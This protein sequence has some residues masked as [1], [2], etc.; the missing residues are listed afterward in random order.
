MKEFWGNLKFSWQYAKDQKWKLY[1]Y[2]LM[3]IFQ[4]GISVVVPILSAKAIVSLTNN[5]L[6]QLLLIAIM[7]FLVENMRNI[8]SYLSRYYAQVI[9]RETFTKLQYTLGKEILKLT[10]EAVDKQGT[11]VFIQRLTN[12]TSRLSDI[13]HFLNSYLTEIITDIGIFIAIFIINKIIFIFLFIAIIILYLFESKRSTKIIEEDKLFRKKQE[14]TS[15]FVGEIVRGMRD[16]KMLNSEKSF[17]DELH[18]KVIEL[19]D[20]RYKIQKID[21]NYILF[22]GTFRDT[23]NLLLIILIVYLITKDNLTPAAALVVY[24]YAG[25]IP[26]ITNCIGMLLDKVKDFNLSANRIYAIIKH[27]DDFIK[28]EFGTTHLENVK[29]NFEFKNVSFGYDKQKILKNLS[30]KINSH[31]TVAFVGKSGAGKTTIFNLLCKMYNIEKGTISIDDRDIKELDR[32]SIRGNITIIS[33]NP[34]IFNLSIKD[35]LR[36]VKENLTNKEMKEACKIACLEDFIESL[37]DKYNTIIGEGGVNLSGGQ[38]Q[39]LAI[40]RALIQKTE[41]ILFDEATSALDNETQSKIQEAIDN[42]K[43]D[44]TILIIAHRLS[45][46]INCDRILFLDDGKIESEGTHEE[47]LKKSKKYKQLYESEIQKNEDPNNC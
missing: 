35:N 33:Q 30:F 7:I 12:D 16:I 23:I 29:G 20:D 17:M 39:R 37:P 43:N 3:S 44:Y 45:T 38:K 34:Y 36:L 22:S 14:K 31:E 6:H 5:T 41:I 21:R 46:I 9:Y 15:S 26:N 8:T 47:L 2:L 4:V 10:N 18:N 1:K 13:F 40:A 32:E 42:M 19:N 25:R 24:N 28:E 11:G 27:E